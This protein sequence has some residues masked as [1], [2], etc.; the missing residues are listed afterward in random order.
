MRITIDTEQCE[1]LGVPLNMMLYLVA[2]Y[3]N[4]TI[5]RNMAVELMNTSFV[6][7]EEWDKDMFPSKLSLTPQGVSLVEDWILKSEFDSSPKYNNR[8]ENLANE[9]RELYPKGK[10]PGTAYMWRDSVPIIAKKLK[11]LV[12]K[13]GDCFTDEQAIKAT[14][15]YVESFNGNYQYMQL[16]KYFI[17]KQT[18]VNGEIEETSQL[19]SYIVNEEQGLEESFDEM[20]YE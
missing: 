11:A 3:F 17:S 10:K 6:K 20:R 12:K 8:W 9:L 16:L 18:V 7:L 13:Y 1:K 2:L 14:K 4:T 19:L 5:S 15:R